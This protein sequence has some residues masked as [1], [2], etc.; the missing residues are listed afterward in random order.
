[1]KKT[2]LFFVFLF[3]TFTLSSQ[4]VFSQFNDYSIKFGLQG[5]G[6]LPATE[7][8]NNDVQ[9]SFL[10]RGFLRFELSHAFDIELGAGYGRLS[11]TD[12]VKNYWET[13]LLPLD[14]RLILSPFN[15][16]AVNPYAYGGVGYLKWD[17]KDKPASQSTF[18]GVKDNGWDLIVPLGAGIEIKISESVLLDLTAGYTQTFTDDL[19]FYN[20]KS[21]DKNKD[22]DGYWNA[23]LGISFT[24][25]SGSSDKD[26]DGLT[27]SQEEEIGTNPNKSDSDGD[28]LKDGAEFLTYNTDPLNPDTDNDGL[29]DY[30]EIKKYKTDPNSTD[31]DGDG[32]SDSE[33][34]LTYKTDPNK[35]DSDGDGLSDF[36]EV[37]KYKTDPNK[38]DT[39]GDGLSDGTEFKLNTNPLKADSDG[40]GLSDGEEVTKY[41]TNPLAKDTDAGSV[42]DKTEVN[43]GTNPLDP[44][45]DVV[46][47]IKANTPIVLRGVTFATGKSDLTPE[48][49]TVLEKAYNTLIAYPNMKVEI[50]GYTDNVGRASSNKR[51]SQ[52]RANSVNDWL[53]RKGIDANRIQ[54]I[55]MGESNPIAN[56]KTKEGRRL[57]RRIEFLK[58][59]K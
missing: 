11:G 22:Y 10:G 38:A 29:N 39:D 6:L 46:L 21:V 1:M 24:T 7:F 34:V 41:K 13:T 55:G 18:P 25:E 30:E 32:L 49:E 36:D 58:I 14:I 59:T 44:K 5:N 53:V 9:V 48:S 35:V 56:N 15:M 43:R 33:E 51:L 27:K 12:F 3:L 54:A 50:R 23:G 37:N 2:S 57:N 52:R 17:V 20:N 19:N 47:K 31:T 4:Q 45:D 8:E 28:G 40:D 42:D 26:M 16:K